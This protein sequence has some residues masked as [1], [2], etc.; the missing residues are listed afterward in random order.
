MTISKGNRIV[1]LLFIF[2]GVISINFSF[3]NAA[4]TFK[5]IK[6]TGEIVYKKNNKQM[7]Q[8]DQFSE[9]EELLFRTNESRA[10]VISVQ[11]GR[12][13]LAPGVDKNKLSVK[14][15][16]LPASSNISSRDGSI[17]N[18]LDL[19]N[20][21]N[22]KVVIL[23]R[24]K[25]FVGKENF[26][27]TEK[28]FFYIK[29]NYN[30][31]EIPKKLSFEN[32]NIIFDRKEILSIDGKPINLQTMDCKLYYMSEKKLS[33]FVNDFVLVLP[34][35]ENLRSELEILFG[36]ISA[37]SSK[38]KLDEVMSYLND[39]YGRANKTNVV[40]WLQDNMGIEN[41]NHHTK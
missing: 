26:P 39:F 14:S 2:L 21:F 37:K 20:Y 40:S 32:E 24:H 30:G 19:Q 23:N 6:I 33:T 10:A 5:V 13:I 25:V 28:A 27:Q 31:E 22:G 29:Y 34:E 9:N 41:L 11:K 8:G 3:R 7:L 17:L 36:E 35:N 38:D 1:G 18:L 16:L 12:F 4:D 15:N